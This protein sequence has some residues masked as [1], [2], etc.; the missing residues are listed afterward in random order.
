MEILTW[1]ENSIVAQFVR[2]FLYPLAQIVHILSF[3]LLIGAIAIFDLRLFGYARRLPIYELARS[4]F[5]LA[6][7]G[8]VLALISGTLLFSAHPTV[9]IVNR[10]F[11]VKL[12]AIALA[13]T[14]AMMFHCKSYRQ[15]KNWDKGQQVSPSAKTIAVFSL[16]FW[17]IAIACGRL[18]A[19]I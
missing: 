19:Y 18:I 9:L 13:G 12:L 7:I 2:Q 6:R 10:A 15:M 1:L 5:P 16:I 14:N 4:I 11:Q 8:F 17:T 3:S